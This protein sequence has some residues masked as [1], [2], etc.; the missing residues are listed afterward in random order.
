MNVDS[1]FTKLNGKYV[2][3][4]GKWG[5]QCVDSMRHYIKERF[6]ID[7]YKIIPPVN[8]A[9]NAFYNYPSETE[10][11]KKIL[12][13]PTNVPTKG[14]IIFF[15]TSL[16]Y[17]WLYGIAGHVE[18]VSQA[19]VYNMVNFAQ[20]WPTNSPCHFQKRKYKDTIGWLTPLK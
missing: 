8:Y 15:K 16:W 17:P 18:I 10:Y 9:K 3:Y 4:D 1:Y 14:D 19:D 12:N 20:N 7:A 6:G 11:F 2:D 5:F 13:S